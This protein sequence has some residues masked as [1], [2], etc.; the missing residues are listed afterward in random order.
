MGCQSS[1]GSWGESLACISKHPRR[2]C[3]SSKSGDAS[4]LL[5]CSEEEKKP[6]DV[7]A[8]NES[9]KMLLTDLHNRARS[10]TK[11]ATLAEIPSAE[12]SD[13]Q[14]RAQ[15]MQ[16]A[17]HADVWD[18]KVRN[19]STGNRGMVSHLKKSSWPDSL[20][21]AM[22]A[23]DRQ[24]YAPL[25][26]PYA[27]RPQPIGNGATISAPHMHSLALE[28]LAGHLVP[29]ARI[30]DIGCG[31]GY[32]SACMARM[33]GPSG[34]VIGVDHLTPLVDLAITNIKK[35]DAD[36]LDAQLAI[37]HGD[38]WKG[39]PDD[40]PFDCIHVGAAAE[41]I[42]ASLLEQ[43]KPGGRMVIPVGQEAQHFYQ[44]DRKLNGDYEKQR[45]MGVRY[46]PLVKTEVA[47]AS[48]GI[49]RS[50]LSDVGE[51]VLEPAEVELSG[52]DLDTHSP[53]PLLR[54]TPNRAFAMNQLREALQEEGAER[55]VS[56]NRDPKLFPSAQF[57]EEVVGGTDPVSQLMP[58]AD[59]A[60]LEIDPSAEKC[61][62]C[63]KTV[64]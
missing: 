38:G 33:V 9:A 52:N 15:A 3:S 39:C 44:I 31:S 17:E 2:Q 8:Q 32:L 50:S 51:V 28:R 14:M 47:A 30:L 54:D 45:L 23:T 27:D 4:A 58:Y 46:V 34:L 12:E 36:L 7:A 61:C 56:T 5:K 35:A 20:E 40:A 10:S 42:P 29:G 6:Q 62:R 57:V 59:E 64:C 26:S 21:K 63:I 60:S 13:A 37:L 19:A 22:L 41:S 16:V 55:E 11:A 24:N 25:L 49:F 48:F 18:E 53:A 1:K 43:L